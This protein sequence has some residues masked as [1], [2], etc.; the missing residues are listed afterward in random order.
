M[1]NH[2]TPRIQKNLML[3][4]MYT[5]VDRRYVWDLLIGCV[6]VCVCVGGC[7][8]VRVLVM[9]VV[10]FQCPHGGFSLSVLVSERWCWPD[11]SHSKCVVII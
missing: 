5:F 8:V 3:C 7:I 6:C 9:R 4:D 11:A 1:A 2:P 10:C